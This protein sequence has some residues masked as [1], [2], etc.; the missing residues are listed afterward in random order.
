MPNYTELYI[1]SLLS[2][3][4]GWTRKSIEKL[5][6]KWPP[7]KG[8]RKELIATNALKCRYSRIS[9]AVEASMEKIRWIRGFQLVK[10]QERTPEEYA[11]D[12]INDLEE[13]GFIIVKAVK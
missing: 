6:L 8:W 5:G 4:G 3:K 7:R 12:F 9:L 11:I 1:D 13:R 10:N 2:A